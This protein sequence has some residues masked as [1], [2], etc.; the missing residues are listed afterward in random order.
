MSV[1]EINGMTAIQ[2][3][4]NAWHLEVR[5]GHLVATYKEGEIIKSRCLSPAFYH[6]FFFY[7]YLLLNRQLML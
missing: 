5:M 6:L 2:L 4:T 3:L 1:F 7:T